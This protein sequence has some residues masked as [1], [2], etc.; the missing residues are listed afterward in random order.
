MVARGDLGV[1]V[2]FRELPVIQRRI[3]RECSR[4]GKPVIV[5][6][7]LL[8]S[9][10][11][12]P[13]PTRAEV[14]DVANAVYEQADAIMLSG[15]TAS[16]QNPV[17]CVEVMDGI[18]KRIEREPGLGFYLARAP[19]G[20]REEIARSACRVADSL[21]AAAIVVITRR[22]LLGQL[23]ASY[24]P[25]HSIIYAFTN[26]SSVRRKL[27]LDRSV[28]PF[29]ID[30]SKNPEKTIQTALDK[31]AQRNRVLAGDP[32]VVITDVTGTSVSI[33]SIQVRRFGEGGITP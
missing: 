7:H 15:E 4:A 25:Q 16:G 6:T 5:A 1:E 12:A 22:G 32:V 33:P 14:T 9:M 10:R 27:W 2:D 13:M 31:L 18:A 28:V 11:E 19:E 23:V 20:A 17:R 30:F 8:E 21:R 29:V 24:R 26:M 3:V